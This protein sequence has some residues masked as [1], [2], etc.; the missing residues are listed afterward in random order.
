MNKKKF[1]IKRVKNIVLSPVAINTNSAGPYLGIS[2]ALLR[3]MREEGR[4]PKFC[5]IGSRI[6]Y[7]IEDLDL[8]LNQSVSK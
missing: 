6:V 2:G 4:G 7:R 5:K 1:I 8:F 3:K